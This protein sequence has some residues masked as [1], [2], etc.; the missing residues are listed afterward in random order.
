MRGNIE[1]RDNVFAGANTIIIYNVK[2]NY[3][4]VIAAD[5]VV[6]KRLESRYAYGSPG[7]RNGRF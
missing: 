6:A 7:W 4:I 3:N 5:V 2:I 1:I